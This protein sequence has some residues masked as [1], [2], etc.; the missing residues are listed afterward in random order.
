MPVAEGPLDFRPIPGFDGYFASPTGGIWSCRKG[1]WRNMA[2]HLRKGRIRGVRLYDSRRGQAYTVCAPDLIMAAFG[3]PRPSSN[4][5]IWYADRN[6]GNLAVANMEWITAD[7]W[8]IRSDRKGSG[9]PIAKLNEVMVR[10]IRLLV[11]AGERKW[12]EWAAEVGCTMVAVRA[13]ASRRTFKHTDHDIPA[14]VPGKRDP[15]R[16][17]PTVLTE[18]DVREARRRLALREKPRTIK[19]AFPKEKRDAI[20]SV[21]KGKTWNHVQ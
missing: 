16:V 7:E 1:R 8:V 20:D 11:Q 6:Y 19:A 15:G 9:S 21:L 13:A 18:D 14:W 5:R 3:Q 2:L 12:A 10:R 4:H 17:R